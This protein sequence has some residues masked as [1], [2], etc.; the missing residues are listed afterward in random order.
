LLSDVLIVIAPPIYRWWLDR[1]SPRKAKERGEK[2]KY[3]FF[4]GRVHSRASEFAEQN[5]IVAVVGHTHKPWFAG[6]WQSP[7]MYD[8][9]DMVDS[10]TYLRI[11][12]GEVRRLS[13]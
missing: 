8:D 3:N 1:I 10:W 11:E 9:G 13:L 5:S 2:E 12:D 4:T 7:V 6:D